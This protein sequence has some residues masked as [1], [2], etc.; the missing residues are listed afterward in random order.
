MKYTEVEKERSF[1]YLKRLVKPQKTFIFYLVTSV[2]SNGMSRRIRFFVAKNNDLLDIS[3]SM[4]VLLDQKCEDYRGMF[5]R[6]CGMDMGFNAVYNLGRILYPDGSKTIVTG[7]NGDTTPETDGGY[8][9]K[10]YGI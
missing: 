4:A 8:L 5:T 3:H 9:L 1:K 2:A 10:Y 7:R 6:G